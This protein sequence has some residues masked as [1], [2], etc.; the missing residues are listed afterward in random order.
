MNGEK[1]AVSGEREANLLPC[2][3]RRE[4]YLFFGSVQQ[5]AAQLKRVNSKLVRVVDRPDA[6]GS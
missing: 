1:Y 5:G 6:I 4:R 3:F 2:L